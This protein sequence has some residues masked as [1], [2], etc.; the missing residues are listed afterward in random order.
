MARCYCIPQAAAMNPRPTLSD[1]VAELRKN[2]SNDIDFA[3]RVALACCTL[4]KHDQASPAVIQTVFKIGGLGG[5]V[6]RRGLPRASTG[7][8]DGA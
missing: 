4:V 3:Q 5:V 8:R 6:L 1:L 7:L 2:S